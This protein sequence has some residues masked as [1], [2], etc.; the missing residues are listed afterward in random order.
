MTQ[1]KHKV[2]FAIVFLPLYVLLSLIGAEGSLLCFGD[3]GHVAIEL[4]QACNGSSLLSSV[5]KAE[6]DDACGSCIDVE[7][8]SSTARLNHESNS[9]TSHVQPLSFQAVSVVP[10]SDFIPETQSRSS[11]AFQKSLTSLK[12]V[13]LLI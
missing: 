2:I 8:Q 10:S 11:I 12:S 4:V 7:F 9:L 3:D 5:A 6:Q 13:V 1:A